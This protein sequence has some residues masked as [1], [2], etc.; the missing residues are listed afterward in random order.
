MQRHRW[1]AAVAAVF[2]IVAAGLPSNGGLS[3]PESPCIVYV[4]SQTVSGDLI[5][6]PPDCYD[7]LARASFD[8]TQMITPDQ[9]SRRTSG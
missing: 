9:E 5:T 1:T 6:S 3:A 2:V 4:L 7:T 8:G